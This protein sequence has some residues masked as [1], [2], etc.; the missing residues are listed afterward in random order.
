[1]E[2]PEAFKAHEASPEEGGRLC[3]ICQ[4]AIAPGELIGPCPSCASTFHEECW[5]EN[6]GCAVYGC[7][8]MPQTVKAEGSSSAPATY[9]GREFK[10]CPSC[11]RQIRVAA[12]RCRYCGTAFDTAAPMT[13]AEHKE[14]VRRTTVQEKLKKTSI[15]LFV[16]GLI[17]C[18][19][20]LT[21]ILGGIWFLR[22]RGDIRKLPAMNRV[23]C[24]VGL[25]ASVVCTA[26]LILAMLVV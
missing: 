7:E 13:R 21:A 6:G 20:P 23:Y 16:C 15:T 18:L 19:A 5:G 12:V 24:Y 14:T 11:R 4:T 1:M 26:L 2:T 9:W 8:R 3:A 25:I 22:N 10:E 17:P